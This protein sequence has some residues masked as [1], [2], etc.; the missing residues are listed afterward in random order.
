MENMELR[1]EERPYDEIHSLSQ[2]IQIQTV[3]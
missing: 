3:F 1:R 2:G